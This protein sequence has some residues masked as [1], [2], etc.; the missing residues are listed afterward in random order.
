MPPGRTSR[1]QGGTGLRFLTQSSSMWWKRDNNKPDKDSKSS[2]GNNANGSSSNSSGN[3]SNHSPS[4]LSATGQGGGSGSSSPP[5]CIFPCVADNNP[6]IHYSTSWTLNPHPFF[7]TSHETDVVGSSLSF[8]F[9]GTGI[10][11]FGTIPPSNATHTPPTA[12]YRVDNND[13]VVTTQSLATDSVPNQPLFA[14][15]NLP[16]GPHTLVIKVT[17]VQKESPYSI[18]FFIVTPVPVSHPSAASSSSKAVSSSS[19]AANP[20]SE[21][22]SASS[23]VVAEKAINNPSNGNS[24]S[25]PVGIIAGVLG[26]II[27]LLVCVGAFFFVR[28]RWRRRRR[29]RAAKYAPSSL[30]TTPESIMMYSR[31]PSSYYPFLQNPWRGK[32]PSVSEKSESAERSLPSLPIGSYRSSQLTVPYGDEASHRQRDMHG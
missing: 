26:A 2:D 27:F 8:P 29:Q 3:K 22:P 32:Q 14:K 21:A 12:A 19:A 18:D 13:P 5:P 24:S 9:T 6:G 17:D 11:V 25:A 4:S 20:S 23:S 30:F 7:Q 16:P 10:T 31:A 15:S 1:G 28:N